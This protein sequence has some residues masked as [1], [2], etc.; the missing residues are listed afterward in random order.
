METGIYE[1]VINHVFKTK[2]Q[3]LDS[4]Q[5]YIGEQNITANNVA[6]Y[7]SNYLYQIIQQIIESLP[8]DDKLDKSVKLVNDI[9]LQVGQTFN[10]E[11]YQNNLLDAPAS[12][13]TAVIDQTKIDYPNI[14]EYLQNITPA[15]RLTKSALFT[16]RNNELNMASELRRE[17]LSSD[18]ICLL[19][20]FIKNSGLALIK[21]E[22]EAF[23]N[24]GHRLR[25]ITTTYMGATQYKAIAS[26]AALPNTQVKISYNSNMDRLHAKAYLFLR[27]SQFHTAYVG[28]SNL[29]EPALRNG[30]EWNIKVTRSESPQIIDNIRNSF[31]TY[32]VD[33]SF[34]D[35]VLGRDNERLKNALSGAQNYNP[36]DYSLLDLIKAKDYQQ[37]ILEKLS[38]ERELHGH[39]K[40]LVV[41]ATG[42][43]KTVIAAFDYK[44]FRENEKHANFLF[45]VHRE[46]III[47]ARDVFRRVLQDEN[48]GETWVGGNKPT[49]FNYV[50]AS[51]DSLNNQLDNLSLANDYYDYIIIDEAHHV[52]A[53]SYQKILQKFNPKILLGLTATPER[54]DGLDI[55]K[56]FGDSISAEIRLTTALNNGLLCPFHYHGITDNTDLKNVRWERGRF[57]AS[58]LSKV[59]TGND[60]RTG[61]I[62]K[63]MEEYL[64]DCHSIQALCFCV[65][66]EH[67]QYMNAKFT[68]GGLKSG[69]LTSENSEERNKMLRLLQE[70][71]INYLFVVDMFNE[72]VD[73]P[74]VD[75]ILFLRPTESLTIFLQQLGRGLRKAK[76]KPYLTVLDFVGQYRTE[77]NF[78]DRFRALIGKTSMGVKE[79]IERDFP[80]L[81]L[82]CQIHLESK[83][84][85][86]I[87]ENINSAVASFRSTRIIS[88]IEK[89]EKEHDMPLTLLNFLKVYNIPLDKLYQNGS[90]QTLCLNAG[91][92]KETSIAFDTELKFAV[93]KKWLSTDSY[94]YFKFIHSLAEKNFDIQVDKMTSLEQK[95]C[96]M[97]YYDFYDRA[98]INL[99]LQEL[100]NFLHNHPVVSEEIRDL[101]QLFIKRCEV[102]E[103]RDNSKIAFINPLCLHGRY[104]KAQIQVAIETSTLQQKSSSRE[105]VERNK[106]L[107]VEAMYVDI[108]KDREENSN[109]NYNDFAMTRDLFHWET[110]NSVSPES[111][112][113]QAYINQTQTMLLFVREQ[114]TAPENKSRTMGY[115]YLG[116]VSL[117]ST[118]GSKPMRIIWKLKT[119]MPA[120]T[121]SFAAKYAAVTL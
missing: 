22:L 7:L 14:S 20:S 48:F 102:V 91:L 8:V 119:P 19:V 49:S 88:T 43:G 107:G 72:G 30:L 28:S 1:Q 110:Q 47:Q 105:G 68:L 81:P 17:I 98:G 73:I 6:A 115:I 57:V 89:F 52:A 23:V 58:E 50:F 5:F 106:N 92:K 39:Y 15:T 64:D 114:S 10:L 4:K 116:E 117:V 78:A 24:A 109:T 2:I 120:S 46:E 56:Y 59:Y 27:D 61:M 112:A 101:M 66:Q 77:Y 18:E 12:I 86:Y 38:A 16:G 103:K 84:K 100:F 55:Q 36:L 3:A 99:S 29:S 26:I 69:V 97:L 90:W 71:K 11:D 70:K 54:M 95:M 37:E 51:K 93:I 108:V 33:D 83:A 118:E 32:W 42:T 67:A 9:I 25:I 75:T 94:T 35:F 65:D 121:Y 62:W 111:T 34:E 76:N 41:A 40:N 31:E 13:L 60:R 104:T 63:A 79:E 82:N 113:G 74:D 85:Q 21:Q 44:R 45:V 53:P 96:L 87:I 80:H